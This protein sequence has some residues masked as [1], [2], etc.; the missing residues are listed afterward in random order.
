MQQLDTHWGTTRPQNPVE[1]TSAAQGRSSATPSSVSDCFTQALYPTPRDAVRAATLA[2]PLW[3]SFSHDR[4]RTIIDQARRHLEAHCETLALMAWEETRMGRPFDKSV[5]NSIAT[6]KTPGPEFLHT[7]EPDP[8]RECCVDMLAPYGVICAITPST[9]PTSTVI[10]NAIS[11]L[12]AGNT[13]FFQPHPHALRCSRATVSLLDA[14]LVAA[15]APPGCVVTHAQEAS[16]GVDALVTSPEIR[17]VVATGGERMVQAAF[18]SRK[19][20]I[21]AGPGNP[22]VIVDATADLADAAACI[23]QG[24][25][26]DNNIMCFSEKE[27]VAVNEV[28]DGLMNELTSRGAY[29]LSEAQLERA[30]QLLLKKR[31]GVVVRNREFVGQ[32]ANAILSHLGVE[33][34]GDTQLLVCE[35]GADHPFVHLEMLM[36]VLPMVRVKTFAEALM[37]AYLAEG[38]RR[39][40][41]VIHTRDPAHVERAEET[42]QT[43]LFVVNAPS[44]AGAAIGAEGYVSLTIASPTGEGMTTCRSFAR[45][46]RSLSRTRAL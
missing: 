7:R 23:I 40:T 9:N 11:M 10:N 37:L 32:S 5:K 21:A 6:T 13:V 20:V 17:A 8:A 42:L 26:F 1:V 34:P 30:T 22:P 29:C 19:K 33:P 31:D 25:S 24:A 28:A 45:V 15:G 14:A 35:T 16:R 46:R 38:G 39:H 27:I 41:A 12:S 3:A 43:T 44:Q 36:P 2:Q 18:A 4:K